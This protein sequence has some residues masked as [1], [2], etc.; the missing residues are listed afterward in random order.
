M[1]KFILAVNRLMGIGKIQTSASF[2]TKRKS[3]KAIQADMSSRRVTEIV[4]RFEIVSCRVVQSTIEVSVA[5]IHI[6]KLDAR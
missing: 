2:L 6:P 5:N 4:P 3:L 1:G